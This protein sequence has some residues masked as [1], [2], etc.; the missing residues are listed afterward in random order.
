MRILI[1]ATCITDQ[2]DGWARYS[3][4]LIK[5][6]S[7]IGKE[8]EYTVLLQKANLSNNHPIFELNEMETFSLKRVGFGPVGPVREFKFLLARLSPDYDVFHCLGTYLPIFQNYKSVVT[9]HDLKYLRYPSLWGKG[10]R[11]KVFYL[12][13]TLKKALSKAKR[14]IADSQDTK[15]DIV[16]FLGISEDKI[17]VI[18]LATD[19]KLKLASD[20]ACS[21]LE[22]YSINKPY[23]LYLGV[24]LPH[25]NLSGLIDAFAEFKE[26]YD[27]WNTELVITGKQYPAYNQY[28]NKAREVRIIDNI[29]F[30][31]FVPNDH[32]P[33][34]YREAEAFLFPSFHEGF[35][36][37]IL[38]A[39]ECGTPVITSNVSAMP[40]VAGDAAL[41]VNPSNPKEIAEKMFAIM[42][43]DDLKREYIEKGYE[44]VKKFSWEK[45]A[46]E[47]LRLYTEVNQ[48]E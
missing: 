25:K 31:G 33:L 36:L 23:F 42:D 3:Y 37:P 27:R 11:F 40:E 45:T 4:N 8:N 32:L 30:T 28:L 15:E 17:K 48:L 26:L 1:D 44:R 29:I 34:L 41:L 24:N 7:L 9:V 2:M 22:K 6:F 12:K 43:S 38:E 21:I 20:S 39:M 35:G 14:I 13:H 47:T 18:Y 10:F 16:N 5:Q 46:Q 19:L